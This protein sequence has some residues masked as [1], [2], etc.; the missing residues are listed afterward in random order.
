MEEDAKASD[1]RSGSAV[2]GQARDTADIRSDSAV[3]GR[4]RNGDD[5]L[6][7]SFLR[8]KMDFNTRR[9]KLPIELALMDMRGDIIHN[10]SDCR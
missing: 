9:K 7:Q 2:V 8:M 1:N 10:G 6:Q 3:V 4:D 5:H